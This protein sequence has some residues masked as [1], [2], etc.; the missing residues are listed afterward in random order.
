MSQARS[1]EGAAGGGIGLDAEGA[2]PQ[3]LS[4]YIPPSRPGEQVDPIVVR[5]RLFGGAGH[6]LPYG[7]GLIVSACDKT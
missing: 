1:P 5:V 7:D 4:G 3:I 2:Y 6:A